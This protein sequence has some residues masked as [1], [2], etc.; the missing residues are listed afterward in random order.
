MDKQI[1]SHSKRQINKAGDILRS[2]GTLLTPSVASALDLLGDWRS[3]HAYPLQCVYMKLR[4]RAKRV[5]TKALVSQRLKRVPSI[6]LK[7]QRNDNM[8]LTTIQDNRWV[9]GNCR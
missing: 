9:Q 6:V 1:P 8:A 4:E 7:L 3:S 2:S 5:D